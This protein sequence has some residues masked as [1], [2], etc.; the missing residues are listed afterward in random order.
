MTGPEFDAIVDDIDA[1]EPRAHPS[2]L[3]EIADV[4]ALTGAGIAVAVL[5]LTR[6]VLRRMRG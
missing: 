2:R 3:R 4:V 1:A 5:L 6:A